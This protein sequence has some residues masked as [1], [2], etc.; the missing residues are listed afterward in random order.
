MSG[1]EG[2]GSGPEQSGQAERGVG[3]VPALAAGPTVAPGGRAGCRS[4][5]ADAASRAC[6]AK[7]SPTKGPEVA[8]VIYLAGYP[9]DVGE[10]MYDFYGFEMP[11]LAD[12]KGI[13]PPLRNPGEDLYNDVPVGGA[14]EKHTARLSHASHRAWADRLSNAGWRDV[15]STFIVTGNDQIYPPE[16]QEK[17]A[18]R[19]ATVHHLPSGHSPFFSMPERL[20]APRRKSPVDDAGTAGGSTASRAVW[21]SDRQPEVDDPLSSTYS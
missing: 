1:G 8:H 7:S 6:D 9:L 16:L 11:A 2:D 15:P 17:A 5:R 13:A 4:P 20:A 14:R 3:R 19:L 10:S 12:L 18:A 21:S